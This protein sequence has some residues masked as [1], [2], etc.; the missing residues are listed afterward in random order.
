MSFGGKHIWDESLF[1]HSFINK[2]LTY[3]SLSFFI[4]KQ[5]IIHPSEI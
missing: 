3:L 5:E 4:H 1:D 2:L